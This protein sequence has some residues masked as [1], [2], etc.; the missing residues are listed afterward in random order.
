MKKE[1]FFYEPD[2]VQEGAADPAAASQDSEATDAEANQDQEP[3]QGSQELTADSV[4]AM[5]QEAVKAA[6]EDTQKKWQSKFDSKNTELQ[7]AKNQLSELAKAKMTAEE[8]A[9]HER[10][11]RQKALEAQQRDLQEKELRLTRLELIAEKSLDK[12]VEPFLVGGSPDEIRANAE[13][14]TAL[15]AEMVAAGVKDQL[16]TSAK[17][18][19]GGPTQAGGAV[20]PW[21][22]ETY[23]LTKQ[24]EIL[25]KDPALAATMKA[26]A[27]K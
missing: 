8:L 9:E 24:A 26:A 7:K 22:R 23:N 4:Q 19:S 5:I 27:G 6:T 20:N 16:K 13:A 21:A 11:E 25:K 12:R 3:S 2:G 1:R 17:P 15:L 18:N 10:E 14:L